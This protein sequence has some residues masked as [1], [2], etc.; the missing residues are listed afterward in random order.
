MDR[1]AIRTFDAQFRG[2][3]S[4][5]VTFPSGNEHPWLISLAGSTA[6]SNAMGRCVTDLT[7]RA[8]TTQQ[9]AAPATADQGATQPFGSSPAPGAAPAPAAPAAAPAQSPADQQ[10]QPGTPPAAAPTPA[11][12]AH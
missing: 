1:G 12:A 4:M 3:S 2:A 6:A 10:A 11:P 9:P 8:A 7:Q 5:T